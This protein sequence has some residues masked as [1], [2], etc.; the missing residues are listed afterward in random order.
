MILREPREIDVK[1]HFP[2][3]EESSLDLGRAVNGIAT[4]ELSREERAE[5]LD[6]KAWAQCWRRMAAQ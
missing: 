6:V 3:V 2:L 5:L 4:V 1:E